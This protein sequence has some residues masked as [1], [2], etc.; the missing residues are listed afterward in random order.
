[1]AEKMS[2]IKRSNELNENSS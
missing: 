1:M 2:K